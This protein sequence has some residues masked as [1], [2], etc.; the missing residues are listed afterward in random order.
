MILNIIMNVN[1]NFKTDRLSSE[2]DAQGSGMLQQLKLVPL[3]P[4][5][6]TQDTIS[7][8]RAAT[9]SPGTRNGPWSPP[10]PRMREYILAVK[11]IWNTWK[12]GEKLDFQGEH[13]TH[14]LM[15]PMFTP[16]PMDCDV[17]PI[18]VSGLGPGM[19][20]IA[21]EVAD[22][23]LLHPMCSPKYIN[24]II[25]PAVAEGAKRSNR[26]PREC[27]LLWGGFIATGETEEDLKTAKRNVAARISFYASTRTYRPALEFHGWGDINEALH[28][29][30]IEGK[31]E[32]MFALVTDDMVETLGF[33]GTGVE[34]ANALK[35]NLGPICSAAMWN[36]VEH[37]GTDHSKD[38]HVAMFRAIVSAIAAEG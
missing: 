30:S 17:P 7:L 35:N 23:L 29:L 3:V 19:A 37:L 9:A 12:T 13:Y 21:G 1:Q 28:K 25:L 6:R 26:D 24:D 5:S 11:A 32:E 36:E 38:E 4:T 20:R 27:E 2:V 18:Y 22:G 16:P 34:V 8:A 14:T 10:A 31:W 15:T 33:C